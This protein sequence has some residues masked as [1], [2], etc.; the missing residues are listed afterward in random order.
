MTIEDTLIEQ[1]D[2]II[3]VMPEYANRSVFF[4]QAGYE[5]LAQIQREQ[6]DK[7]DLAALKRICDNKELQAEILDSLQYQVEW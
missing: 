2:S 6:R 1:V 5:K 3:A 7:K 4:E